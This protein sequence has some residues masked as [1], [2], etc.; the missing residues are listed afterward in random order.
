MRYSK[1]LFYLPIGLAL[2]QYIYTGVFQL[3]FAKPVAYLL[4][5]LQALSLVN[6]VF[7]MVLFLFFQKEETTEPT[8]SENHLQVRKAYHSKVQL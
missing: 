7:L 8:I 2:F 3:V 5:F 4:I 6:A 1:Y